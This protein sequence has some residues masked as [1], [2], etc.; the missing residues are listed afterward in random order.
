MKAGTFFGYKCPICGSKSDIFAVVGT[1]E[2]RCSNCGA[3][4]VP[5]PNGK[6]STA[7]A[8]CPNCKS[9]SGLVN[10]DRCPTC[11]GPFSRLP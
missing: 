10:S 11:G 7:N 6:T 4:M 8:Y 9:F 2:P 5:D 3:T 1:D